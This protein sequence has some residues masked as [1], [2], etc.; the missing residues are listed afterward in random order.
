MSLWQNPNEEAQ[1]DAFIII[2]P[3]DIDG[4]RIF[5][6]YALQVVHLSIYYVLTSA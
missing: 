6:T 4:H 2:E 1:S 3:I 5:T